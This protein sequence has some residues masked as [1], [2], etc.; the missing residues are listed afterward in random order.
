[1]L[2]VATLEWCMAAGA[3]DGQPHPQSHNPLKRE[4]DRGRRGQEG[5]RK[6][7][8]GG[9]QREVTQLEETARRN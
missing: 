6:W 2:T 4:C 7:E 5:S 9:A 1:M 8:D 3:Q